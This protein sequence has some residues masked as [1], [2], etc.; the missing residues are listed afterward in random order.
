M[1]HIMSKRKIFTIFAISVFSLIFAVDAF[2][3]ESIFETECHYEVTQ[4][5]EDGQLISETKTRKC[6]EETKD[7]NK[8]DPKHNFKDYVKVQ[9]V[10]VGLLGIVIALAK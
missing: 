7:S 3:E 6:K 10:D 8:F 5:F 9:L 2:A 4:V 1:E